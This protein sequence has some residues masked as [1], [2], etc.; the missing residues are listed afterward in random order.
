M[1]GWNGSVGAHPVLPGLTVHAL[2]PL[3]FLC[4]LSHPIFSLPTLCQD[5]PPFPG[6]DVAFGRFMLIYIPQ[7][8]HNAACC[9]H[10]VSMQTLI[11][12]ITRGVGVPFVQWFD[13]ECNYNAMVL[14]LLVLTP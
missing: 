8:Q 7:H 3:S 12:F 9:L 11:S 2:L 4:W 10:L 14:D 1:G 6:M 13:T 5:P